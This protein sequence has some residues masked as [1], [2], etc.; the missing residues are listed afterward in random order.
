[1]LKDIV[2][3][4]PKLNNWTVSPMHDGTV[5]I[6]TRDG[7][8]LSY[9][10]N[11]QGQAVSA[12]MFIDGVKG[13]A[14]KGIIEVPIYPDCAEQKD[15]LKALKALEAHPNCHIRYGDIKSVLCDSKKYVEKASSEAE[16]ELKQK[17][18]ASKLD[19]DY[20]R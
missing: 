15:I 10:F 16:K 14:A 12:N 6:R 4:T 8:N 13:S 20:E 7:I 5:S 1:M 17:A 18:K 2:A 19:R 3:S 9:K 11:E